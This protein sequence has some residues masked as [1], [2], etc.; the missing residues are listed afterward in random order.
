M[1]PAPWIPEA[2]AVCP[3]EAATLRQ[4]ELDLQA[5]PKTATTDEFMA[6]YAAM[7]EARDRLYDAWISLEL[8]A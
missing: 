5:L 1:S 6:M 7:L 2:A 8:D 4:V 3:A